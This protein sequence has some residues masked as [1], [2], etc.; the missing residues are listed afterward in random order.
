MGEEN[1]SFLSIKINQFITF[2]KLEQILYRKAK[3]I[4]NQSKQKFLSSI[5]GKQLLIFLDNVNLLD[6]GSNVGH[7]F[8]SLLT[9]GYYFDHV[10]QEKIYLN[11]VSIVAV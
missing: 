11:N 5:N 4:V 9:L 10:T 2:E 7:F 6:E 1:Y 8:K 3:V